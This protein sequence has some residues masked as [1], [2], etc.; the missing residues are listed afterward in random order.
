MHPAT[1]AVSSTVMTSFM[2]SPFAP[3]RID[4]RE[5]GRGARFGIVVGSLGKDRENSYIKIIES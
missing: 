1:Q 4:A 5:H 2:V 3:A